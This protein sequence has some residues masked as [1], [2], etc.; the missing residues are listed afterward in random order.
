MYLSFELCAEK[1]MISLRLIFQLLQVFQNKQNA[2]S[3]FFSGMCKIS[4]R[5]LLSSSTLS[6]AWCWKVRLLTT[7][8]YDFAFT[9]TSILSCPL[10]DSI[11]RKFEILTVESWQLFIEGRVFW[12]VEKYHF[13]KYICVCLQ[14][15]NEVTV[16]RFTYL[17]GDTECWYPATSSSRSPWF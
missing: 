10:D 13:L 6:S 2:I 7:C 15:F 4:A 14:L 1:E 12:L 16:V 3:L 11:F 17:I 5:D 8:I 9:K